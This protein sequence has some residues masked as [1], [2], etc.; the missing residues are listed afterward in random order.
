MDDKHI[1]DKTI[2]ELKEFEHTL[3]EETIIRFENW[4]SITINFLPPGLRLR[5]K[6]LKFYEVIEDE[7][8]EVPF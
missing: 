4:K 1:W 5:F 6:K 3:N 8:Y 2:S 7:N